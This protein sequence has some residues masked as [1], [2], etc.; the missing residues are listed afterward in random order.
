ML[1]GEKKGRVWRA[2]IAAMR[3]TGYDTRHDRALFHYNI[4]HVSCT[5]SSCLGGQGAG[6]GPDGTSGC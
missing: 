1:Q 4:V 3:E 2:D 5:V 6:S